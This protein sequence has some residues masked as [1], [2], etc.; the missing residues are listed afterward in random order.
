MKRLLAILAVLIFSVPAIRAEPKEYTGTLAKMDVKVSLNWLDEKNVVGVISS[1]DE[2]KQVMLVGQNISSG[3]LK[4]TLTMGTTP[5]GSVKLTKTATASFIIWSGK[6][7]D[8]EGNQTG[9]L[10]LQ[11]AR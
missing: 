6:I 1:L 10:E 11:R 4:V 7:I 2:S 5:K 9:I 3:L 8:P